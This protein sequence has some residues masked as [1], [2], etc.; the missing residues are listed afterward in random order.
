MRANYGPNRLSFRLAFRPFVDA[1]QFRGRST[2]TEVVS[3]WLLGKICHLGVVTMGGLPPQ[4]AATA[5]AFWTIAWYWP[6]IPLLVRRLHDQGRSGRWAAVLLAGSILFALDWFAPTGS[7]L[8]LDFSLGWSDV[9]RSVAW[10]PLTI[11]ASVAA[12]AMSIASLLLYLLPNTEGQN[13][14]GPDP[15]L[16]AEASLVP[17]ET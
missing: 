7:D 13:R 6:W 16:D 14:Y 8:S 17:A 9:H 3:F 15:R 10:T 2:R 12:V 11:A 5:G 1:F 4:L